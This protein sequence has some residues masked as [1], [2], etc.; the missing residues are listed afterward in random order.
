VARARRLGRDAR[1][2]PA[3]PPRGAIWEQL[4]RASLNALDFGFQAVES[5]W[6]QEDVSVDADGPGGTAS[7]LYP[8]AY[9][10][11]DLVDLDP[12]LVRLKV[13]EYGH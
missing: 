1:V 10:L 7:V 3:D 12:A 11:S 13:D 2:R 9:V 4:L 8:R 6:E 5:V